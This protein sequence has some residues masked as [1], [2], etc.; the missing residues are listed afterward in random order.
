MA[1]VVAW[2]GGL[3]GAARRAPHLHRVERECLQ[4]ALLAAH[5]SQSSTSP[6][7]ARAA[8][9]AAAS[10][11]APARSALAAASAA[12]RRAASSSPRAASACC[13]RALTSPSAAAS[14]S[15]NAARCFCAVS[16]SGLPKEGARTSAKKAERG[17]PKTDLKQV[18]CQTLT[19]PRASYCVCGGGPPPRHRPGTLRPHPVAP[20][21]R[22]SSPR[23]AAPQRVGTCARRGASERE[24]ALEQLVVCQLAGRAERLHVGVARG[25]LGARCAEQR[26]GGGDG[27]AAA[28]RP[29][30]TRERDVDLPAQAR[31]STGVYRRVRGARAIQDRAIAAADAAACGLHQALNMVGMRPAWWCSGKTSPEVPSRWRAPAFEVS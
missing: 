21:P 6:A 29:G 4:R 10:T 13:R 26:P 20:R 14:R 2:V 1:W 22:S 3:R 25:L 15:A 16:A 23:R 19:A 9:A 31:G 27:E 24:H 5:L 11:A 30:A 12:S 18:E 8:F 7:S 28:G 17:A